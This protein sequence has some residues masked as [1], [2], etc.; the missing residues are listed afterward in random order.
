MPTIRHRR[1]E[2]RLHSPFYLALRFRFD[3]ASPRQALLA[4]SRAVVTT[5]LNLVMPRTLCHASLRLSLSSLSP[6]ATRRRVSSH[7]HPLL[8]SPQQDMASRAS[9][10]TQRLGPIPVIRPGPTTQKGRRTDLGRAQAS[11]HKHATRADRTWWSGSGRD[12]EQATAS[13][14]VPPSCNQSSPR[15]P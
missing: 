3:L 15:L 4:S 1:Q 7:R 9:G 2:E 11:K 13:T 8:L 6:P 5:F 10:F 12:Q 14:K